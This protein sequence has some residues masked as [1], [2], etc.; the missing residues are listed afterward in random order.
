MCLLHCNG[1]KQVHTKRNKKT[2]TT[3][4][5]TRT[6][7][8]MCRHTHTCA[9]PQRACTGLFTSKFLDFCCFLF[10]NPQQHTICWPRFN[11]SSHFQHNGQK[12]FFDQLCWPEKRHL[13]FPQFCRLFKPYQSLTNY[14]NIHSS[15]SFFFFFFFCN[16]QLYE[17]SLWH[18]HRTSQFLREKKQTKTIHTPL[19]SPTHTNIPI[20]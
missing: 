5:I 1:I 3:I 20:Y 4:P 18:R 12:W 13:N 14:Q 11:K 9:L 7:D 10:L 8:H 2:K 15:S 17:H 16:A 6:H 19:P